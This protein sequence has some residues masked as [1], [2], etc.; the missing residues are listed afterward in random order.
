M[1]PVPKTV[2]NARG[3]Q[4]P[5]SGHLCVVTGC[6]LNI[7]QA[8]TTVDSPGGEAVSL[9][10]ASRPKRTKAG[11]ARQVDPCL[12]AL[13]SLCRSCVMWSMHS[14]TNPYFSIS[15]TCQGETTTLLL[16]YNSFVL[17]I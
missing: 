5:V 10:C 14:L 12:T 11:K 9:V 7:S 8:G 1:A 6:V 13:Q 17:L 2:L 15:L 4:R 3:Q 16:L